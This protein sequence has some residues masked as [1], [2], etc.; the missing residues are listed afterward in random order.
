MVPAINNIPEWYKNISLFSGSNDM[1]KLQLINNIGIDGSYISVK[2]CTPFFDALTFGYQYVLEEDIYVDIDENGEPTVSW[3][4]NDALWVDVRSFA[5]L[6]IPD[7]CHPIQYGWRQELYYETPK[8]HS[9]L[10]T[11]PLN[12]YDLPFLTVSGIVDADIFGMPVFVPFFIK[13][14]FIGKIPK[15]TPMFQMIPFQRQDW[16]L[17]V[18]RDHEI[19]NEKNLLGEKRRTTVSGFYK[20]FVWVK[21]IFAMKDEAS[22]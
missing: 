6:A 9:V 19:I 3:E 10:I 21:K 1:S 4:S 14:N 17:E 2:R 15:G 12:R 7:N 5:D 16:E 8:N 13:K 11:H 20:R 18:V 22:E